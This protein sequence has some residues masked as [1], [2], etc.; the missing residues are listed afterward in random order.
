MASVKK[1]TKTPETNGFCFWSYYTNNFFG[2]QY[3]ASGWSIH[4]FTDCISS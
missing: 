1:W 2:S 4:S 3:F